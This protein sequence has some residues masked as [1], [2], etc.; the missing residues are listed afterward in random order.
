M[1][2][3][4]YLG[5]RKGLFVAEKQ[6]GRWQ[7]TERHFL[8]TQ[9][10]MLLPDPRTGTVFAAADEGHFGTKLYA[11]RKGCQD[12]EQLATPAWPTKP[13]DVPEV[14]DP[15]R[16]LPIPWSLEKIWCLEAGGTD[17][18][19]VL[20]CGTI[21]GG[22][23]RSADAGASWAL[24]RSL[25][26]RPER[27]RW[28]GGGYDYPGIHSICV[29]PRDSRHVLVGISCGGVW[30]TRD[31]GATWEMAATGLRAVYL[32][33][34]QEFDPVS[35]DPHR[36]V[37]CPGAPDHLWIQHHNG[38]F[39]SSDG[40]AS[41]QEI[42]AAQP[43]NFGFGVAVHPADPDTAW[44]APAEADEKRIPVG[45]QLVVSQT[46]DGG[47]HF[48]VRRRGL[49]QEDAYHLVY[50]HGLEVDASGRNLAVGTTTGGV[51]TSGDAGA[52]WQC[53]SNDLPPVFCVR[54]GCDEKE[55]VR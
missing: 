15:I 17:E 33:P 1:S 25:W 54:F 42:T 18:P 44:F 9:I 3:L 10:P 27:A 35:Q 16:N 23:F 36:M 37:Q 47:R 19:G 49:P 21:P 4:L 7:L 55:M 30:R 29:D 48:A 45:G 26:D 31:A 2:A 50:R 51:W 6:G 53:L 5:T 24:V 12:W 11:L 46:T 8:G 14:C 20:W 40:A 28:F 39:R 41:W 43:S 34:G 13:E 38:I 32:P 22:L 52:S